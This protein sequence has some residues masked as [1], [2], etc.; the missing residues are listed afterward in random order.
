MDDTNQIQKLIEEIADNET[1]RLPEI[2]HVQEVI[3]ETLAEQAR[4]E[5]EGAE[6]SPEAGSPALP[7]TPDDKETGSNEADPIKAANGAA[8]PDTAQ[9][10][11]TP[12]AADNTKKKRR[13]KEKIKSTS[14]DDTVFRWFFTFMCMNIPVI[15]WF[16]LVFLSFSK[17]R[18]E[19]RNFA[20]AYLFYK[21]IF[22]L[23]SLAILGCLIYIGLGLLDQLLAYVEML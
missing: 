20:R 9:D 13:K 2:P 1:R 21:L 22:L 10:K 19:R 4:E 18:P 23:I 17:K 3:E 15:G 7:K 14:K 11:K 16:Y 5:A 12:A 8:S 6:A